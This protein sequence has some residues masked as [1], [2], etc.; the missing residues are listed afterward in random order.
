MDNAQEYSNHFVHWKLQVCL[1]LL[2]S[3]FYMYWERDRLILFLTSVKFSSVM[4]VIE[5]HT[6]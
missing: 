3:D 6:L 2:N 4:T 5:I 1:A